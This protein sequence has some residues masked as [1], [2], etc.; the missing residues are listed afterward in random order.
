MK[1]FNGRQHVD[2]QNATPFGAMFVPYHLPTYYCTGDPARAARIEVAKPVMR[3]VYSS[4]FKYYMLD[5][6]MAFAGGDDG[7]NPDGYEGV[8]SLERVEPRWIP[9]DAN[10]ELSHA[11]RRDGALACGDCHAPEGVLDWRALGYTPEEAAELSVDPL[12]GIRAKGRDGLSADGEAASGTREASAGA[13]TGAGSAAGATGV[14][15]ELAVIELEC[16]RGTVTFSHGAHAVHEGVTC[17]TCH[18]THRG[19]DA[20]QPCRRCHEKRAGD[21]PKAKEALHQNCQ[22]CHLRHAD[23]GRPTGPLEDDCEACHV[24]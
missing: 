3:L 19:S 4:M 6:F 22:D 18:H 9:K 7:W 14:P 21:A 1:R 23:A 16:R 17:A 11:V 12:Q 10:L 20:I 13:P 5:D 15:P 24:R 8:A 2:L